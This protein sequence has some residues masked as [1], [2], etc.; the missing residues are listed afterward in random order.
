MTTAQA[1]DDLTLP[2]RASENGRHLA[3]PDGQPFFCQGDTTCAIFTRL[4]R[5]E[6]DLSLRDRAKKG[7]TIIQPLVIGRPF[8]GFEIPSPK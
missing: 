8:D 2:I 4:V 7:F 3:Q 1:A 6:A 5:D